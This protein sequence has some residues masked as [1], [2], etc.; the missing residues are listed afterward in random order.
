MK[1]KDEIRIYYF[2]FIYYYLHNLTRF[3]N[4]QIKTSENTGGYIYLKTK[5][6]QFLSK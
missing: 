3:F 5:Q 4:K 2:F 1:T 6:I